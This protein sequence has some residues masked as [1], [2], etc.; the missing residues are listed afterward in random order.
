[1][2]DN[3]DNGKLKN[4]IVAKARRLA[5]VYADS[6]KRKATR[7]EGKGDATAA[8]PSPPNPTPK[9]AML[10]EMIAQRQGHL[11]REPTNKEKEARLS[12]ATCRAFIE[13]ALRHAGEEPAARP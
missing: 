7:A 3:M 4:N 12:E 2:N 1:M 13:E 10:A 11:G 9:E 8:A 6:I 5:I